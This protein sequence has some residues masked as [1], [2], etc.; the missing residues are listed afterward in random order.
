MSNINRTAKTTLLYRPWKSST[1][2]SQLNST[3]KQLAKKRIPKNQRYL[4]RRYAYIF[5][6]LN[7]I[8][9]MFLRMRVTKGMYTLHFV[10]SRLR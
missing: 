3:E 8:R 5:R 2:T 4:L 1:L 7:N 9:V 6:A 10:K